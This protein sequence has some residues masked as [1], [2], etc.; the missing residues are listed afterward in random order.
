MTREAL[1]A[2]SF[3]TISLYHYGDRPGTPA[4]EMQPKVIEKVKTGRCGQLSREF[5]GRCFHG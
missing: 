3:N 4:A 5:H 1:R 2:M